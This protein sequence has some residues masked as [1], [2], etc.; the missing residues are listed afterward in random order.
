MQNMNLKL[1]I[2]IP[3][4]NCEKTLREAVASC[5]TQGFNTDEFEIVMV[6]DGS[7]DGTR[8]LMEQL[9]TEQPNIKLFF[10]EVNKG[11]GAARNTGIREATGEIIYCLDSDNV[12]APNSVRPMLNYLKE[13]GVDGVAFYER[14][15]FFGTN[16]KTYNTHINI[17]KNVIS[18]I[19]LFD[20]SNTLL[21]NFF[22]TKDSYLKTTGYPEHHGFDTQCFE[23]RYIST[24]NKV[25]V[26]PSSIFYH[27]QA[28]QDKSYFERVHAS[29]M[30]SV[31]FMLIFEDIFHLFTPEVQWVLINFPLFKGNKSYGENILETLKE[32]VRSGE[33]IFIQNYNSFLTENSRIKWIDWPKK[34]DNPNFTLVQIFSCLNN[35][36]YREAQAYLIEYIERNKI[37]TSYIEFL[38]LRILQ[39]IYG[40]NYNASIK[41]VINN[42]SALQIEPIKTKKSF[43]TNWLRKHQYLYQ[44]VQYFLK[45]IR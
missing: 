24:G 20:D 25:K 44:T 7:S 18:L 3:C 28:M 14:R 10:H 30:F 16:L 21:D 11:G 38:N 42:I 8:T 31:N 45:F 19:N 27:R 32:R 6:D 34:D 40:T 13:E 35:S 26:C 23:M 39:G 37:L 17:Q 41:N 29:G 4:Y 22:F 9:A 15:F 43:V 2:I 5:F 36:R 12:F 1:S 33:N